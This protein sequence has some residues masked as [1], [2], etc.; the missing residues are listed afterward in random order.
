MIDDNKPHNCGN[1][2]IDEIAQ[3]K[4]KTGFKIFNNQR[5]KLKVEKIDHQP[6]DQL[7]LT[8]RLRRKQYVR[9]MQ[10]LLSQEHHQ[11][12]S[13]AQQCQIQHGLHGLRNEINQRTI[14]RRHSDTSNA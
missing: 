8:H 11:N 4:V 2:D 6:F 10:G 13:Q 14:Y 3:W 5:D 7:V 1:T 12:N 9:Q